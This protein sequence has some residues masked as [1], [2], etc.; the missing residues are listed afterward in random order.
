M[1]NTTILSELNDTNSICPL[2]LQWSKSIIDTQRSALYVCIIATIIHSILW[3]QLAFSP[4]LRK[5]SIQWLYAYLATDLL[6][7]FRFFFTFIV[8]STSYECL[9]NKIW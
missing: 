1:Y 7:L 6:L 9:P 3:I 4:L 5:K 2:S 8:H